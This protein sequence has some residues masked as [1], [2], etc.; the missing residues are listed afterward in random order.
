MASHPLSFA[1]LDFATTPFLVIWETTQAC[2]LACQ[3]CRAEAQE[4][5]NPGELTT[6]EGK[7]LLDQIHG[8]GTPV[9][10]LSG[11]DP[12]RRPDLAEL[13]RHGTG[14]GLRMA[15]IPAASNDLTRDRLAILRDAGLAQVAFSLDGSTAELHDGFRKVPGTYVKT[16]QAVEWAHEL[17]LP[18]Q[19]NTTFARFNRDDLDHLTQLV[20]RLGVVF[21]EVFSLV[22]VGRGTVL[23]PM[24]AQEHEDF[25]GKLYELSKRVSFIIKLTEAP[26]YRRYVLEQRAFEAKAASLAPGAP[27]GGCGPVEAAGHPGRSHPAGLAGARSAL[28]TRHGGPCTGGSGSA[29]PA[30]LSREMSV[31][32]SFGAR[33]KGINA[34]KGFCFVSHTGEVFPSGFLPIPVGNVRQTPLAALYRESPLFLELRDPTRLKGRCGICEYADICGGSRARAYGATGDYLAED[35]ACIYQPPAK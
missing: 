13:V 3:H 26:H 34:A 31:G 15:T 24:N 14:L 11:G 29:I 30:Q 27:V 12:L 32:D 33:A 21:W 16:M 22:A 23:Q 6:D 1:R 18:V 17:D 7:R 4:A 8:L 2:P 5:R 35:A 28:Q 19:I 9:C 10:V 20:A 25:F